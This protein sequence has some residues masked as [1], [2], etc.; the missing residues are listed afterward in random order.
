MGGKSLNE[1]ELSEG[2]P[3]SEVGVAAGATTF[4]GYQDPLIKAQRSIFDAATVCRQSLEDC[5]D[6]P[7]LME[8]A[9][10]ENR[11]AD[12]NLWAAGVGALAR[13]KASLDKRLALQPDALAVVVNLLILLIE[14][15]ER[16]KELGRSR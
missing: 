15:V 5:L 4:T 3:P 8:H 9:W 1:F 16:C 12:F 14:L 10:A 11:L 13:Q 6:I 2:R 7:S